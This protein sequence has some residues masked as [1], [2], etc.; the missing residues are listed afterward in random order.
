MDTN[1]TQKAKSQ[2]ISLSC[3]YV[4]ETVQK[5]QER[6]STTMLKKFYLEVLDETLGS[7]LAICHHIHISRG[8]YYNWIKNDPEFKKAVLQIKETR[9]EDVEDS[10]M[11][12]ALK[13]N[14][15]AGKF[16]LQ[17][18]HPDYKQR[19]TGKKETTVFMRHFASPDDDLPKIT[20]KELAEDPILYE[21]FIRYVKKHP[22]Y[23]VRDHKLS[24]IN[25][26]SGDLERFREIL[27]MQNQKDAENQKKTIENKNSEE[28][29]K[30]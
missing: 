6:E 29:E 21:R 22:D 12:Q 16:I 30:L 17:H 14:V 2:L 3:A 24:N 28:T 5:R 7:V 15:S 25:I 10:M 1:T 9:I 27:E 18:R 11:K 8:T 23:N 4:I 19:N 13:G 20:W 26:T